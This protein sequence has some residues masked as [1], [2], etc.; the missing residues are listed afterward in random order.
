MDKRTNQIRQGVRYLMSWV[1]SGKIHELEKA[2][3]C[4]QVLLSDEQRK[5]NEQA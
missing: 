2:V 5:M 1:K 3:T 4:F